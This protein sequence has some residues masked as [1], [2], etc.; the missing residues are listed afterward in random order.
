MSKFKIYKQQIEI[1]IVTQICNPLNK[2]LRATEIKV[3]PHPTLQHHPTRHNTTVTAWKIPTTRFIKKA[4]NLRSQLSPCQSGECLVIPQQQ[5]AHIIPLNIVPVKWKIHF[6]VLVPGNYNLILT[7]LPCST[8]LFP[9]YL[10]DPGMNT[11]KTKHT[12]ALGTG[13]MG[14]AARIVEFL[15]SNAGSIFLA[16]VSICRICSS[17]FR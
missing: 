17:I 16:L 6:L 2:Y 12:I 9:H 5:N 1:L 14:M 7:Q 13:K 11:L 8:C 3:N 15:T 10:P 4:Q